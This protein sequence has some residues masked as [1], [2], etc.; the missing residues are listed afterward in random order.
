MAQ[1]NLISMCKGS[2]HIKVKPST[3]LLKSDGQERKV[4]SNHSTCKE[5]TH[6][7]MANHDHRTRVYRRTIY[8]EGKV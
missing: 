3:I 7:S 6:H 1:K 4:H 2:I 8:E 5:D